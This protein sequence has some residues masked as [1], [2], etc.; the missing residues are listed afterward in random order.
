MVLATALLVSCSSPGKSFTY[1]D[2]KVGSGPGATPSQP[3]TT[4]TVELAFALRNTWNQ[5][6]ADVTWELRDT[7]D[8]MNVVV[9]DGGD[10]GDEVDI[11]AFG[12]IPITVPLG[13]LS[14]GSHTYE[15]VIDPGNAVVEEDETNN[16]STT[17]TVVVADQDLA[18]SG[19]PV[20]T[21]GSPASTSDFTIAFTLTNTLHAEATSPG[22]AI[23]VPFEITDDTDAV[24]TPVS[25]ASPLSASV[26]G[27]TDTTPGSTTVTLTMPA[28]GSAGKFV[29][30]ITLW[31]D[32]DSDGDDG[33][34]NNNTRTVT[35]TIPGSG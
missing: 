15:V 28:T 22:G 33:N 19:T 12:S 10:V 25:P 14:A 4:Q 11:P 23:T 3:A 13:A 9:I 21:L 17:L 5:P 35:V 16:T 2:L 32:D 31:P 27:G 1:K 30:T 6:I 26:P 20:I 8:P 24:V 7:T 29:Y 34:L 18:V